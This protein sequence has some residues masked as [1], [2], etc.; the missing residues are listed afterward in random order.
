LLADALCD[1]LGVG[2]SLRDCDPLG[3][4]LCDSDAETVLLADALGDALGDWDPL[5]DCDLLRD[6]DSLGDRD[7]LGDCDP[8][9]DR[10]SLDDCES[11]SDCEPLDDGDCD[12][13]CDCDGTHTC[14]STGTYTAPLI[15]MPVPVSSTPGGAS[16]VKQNVH[17]VMLHGPT[18]MSVSADTFQVT[19]MAPEST[20]GGTSGGRMV[21]SSR[22]VT[23]APPPIRTLSSLNAP[24]RLVPS[25]SMGTNAK[26]SK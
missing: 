15:V 18:L 23:T 20:V 1:L 21:R 16:K 13:D 24:V 17:A 10:D 22:P 8:L 9:D 26:I 7:S 2:D 19:E 5:R 11:L 12:C 3:V 6:W 14:V 25:V 4:G